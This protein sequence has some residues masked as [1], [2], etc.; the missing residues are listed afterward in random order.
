[1][2][3][4]LSLGSWH[5][6][7]KLPRLAL[8]IAACHLAACTLAP[9]PGEGLSGKER[10]FFMYFDTQVKPVLE[11]HC[12]QC[13]NGRQ[14]VPAL[15]LSSKATA[16]TKNAR[17]RD[18]IVPGKPGSSL[19]I[20]AVQRGGTHPQMMPRT[21]LSLTEDQIGA[22]REWIDDGAYWPEG[23]AGALHAQKSVENP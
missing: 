1:M 23:K 17:G 4:V 2:P 8:F 20:T 14:K 15:D 16:F 19:L 6:M 18:Y 12:L 7:T 13:H 9:T 11:Q 3:S 10:V 5:S 22:L 21:D